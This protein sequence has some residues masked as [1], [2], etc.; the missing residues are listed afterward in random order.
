MHYYNTD[1]I[2]SEAIRM[3]ID[4]APDRLEWVKLCHALKRLGEDEE[5]FVALSSIH[6]TKEQDSR[7]KWRQERTC[8]TIRTQD[9]ARALIA[10]LAKQYGVDVSQCVAHEGCRPAKPTAVAS[11]SPEPLTPQSS[12]AE[13]IPNDVVGKFAKNVR[14]T[15]LWIFLAKVFGEDEATQA[16]WLYQAGGA[17]MRDRNG[18]SVM[19]LPY[20]NADG[21]CVDC[22][23]WS[24]NPDNGKS[25]YTTAEGKEKRLYVGWAHDLLR[26]PKPE[27]HE[28]C[29]F[30]DHLLKQRPSAPIGIVESEKTA[31][32]ASI[33]YKEILWVAV[34]SVTNF[35]PQ[36]CQQYAGRKIV[37][38]PD[39]DGVTKWRERAERLRLYGLDVRVA[40]I[41][42]PYLGE[43]NDDLADLILRERAGM[44]RRA[45]TAETTTAHVPEAVRVWNGMKEANPLL[46]EFERDFGL[47]AVAIQQQA[48]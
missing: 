14:E 10:S 28:W 45:D 46:S 18:C 20:I 1:K 37:A 48:C 43:R 31:I 12:P 40:D 34:G 8:N 32:I 47:V 26:M 33:V 4:I 36:R 19:T 17:K 44:L 21:C 9:D 41:F 7:A 35:N 42:G 27:L 6:G 22:K 25:K 24:V 5:T 29:N 2:I 15:G 39:R 16:M 23:L 38:Y 13:P 3:R 30:G 11:T